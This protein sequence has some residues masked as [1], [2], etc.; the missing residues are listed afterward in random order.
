MT[1]FFGTDTTL[2]K[3]LAFGAGVVEEL[4]HEF[5]SPVNFR[6]VCWFLKIAV[7]YS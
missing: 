2:L 4:R 1:R 3:E 7:P 5:I 6:R